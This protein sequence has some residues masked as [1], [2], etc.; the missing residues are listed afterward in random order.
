MT[1]PSP[2]PP[3]ATPPGPPD[4]LL[5]T[6]DW[7]GVLL[8]LLGVATMAWTVTG[9]AAPRVLG[10]SVATAVALVAGVAW[11]GAEYVRCRSRRERR[12]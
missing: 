9:G 1:A 5:D 3:A 12:S 8:L 10:G 2:T 6:I 11:I 7:P 4:A